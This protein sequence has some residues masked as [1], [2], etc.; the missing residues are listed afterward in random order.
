M[1]VI[2][3]PAG[4]AIA[5]GVAFVAGSTIARVNAPDRHAFRCVRT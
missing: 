4:A 3:T 5:K 2:A 1:L